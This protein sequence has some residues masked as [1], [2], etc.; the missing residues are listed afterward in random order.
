MK[1]VIIFCILVASVAG[2]SNHWGQ[3]SGWIWNTDHKI[4]TNTIVANPVRGYVINREFHFPQYIPN[5]NSPNITYIEAID[6]FRNSSGGHGVIVSGGPKYNYVNMKFI[7]RL[8]YGI[9]FTVKIYGK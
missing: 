4:Y 1:C 7:S 5:K 6:N 8:G 2:E 3:R 9:N